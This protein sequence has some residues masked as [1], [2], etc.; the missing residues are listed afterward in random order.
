MVD[1]EALER[2]SQK[3]RAKL[4]EIMELE[5]RNSKRENRKE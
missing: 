3:I 4:E 1:Y 2:N 5:R